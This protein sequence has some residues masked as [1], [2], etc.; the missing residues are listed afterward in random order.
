MPWYCIIHKYIEAHAHGYQHTHLWLTLH[1]I[2]YEVIVRVKTQ[3]HV[4]KRVVLRVGLM[5]T[6]GITV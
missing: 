6:F 4:Q 1:Q 3:S 5:H 2:L